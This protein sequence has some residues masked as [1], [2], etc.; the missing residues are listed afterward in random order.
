MVGN[1]REPETSLEDSVEVVDN[2]LTRGGDVGGDDVEVVNGVE[3]A[4]KILLMVNVLVVDNTGTDAVV[5][6]PPR[7]LQ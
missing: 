3:A 1:R 4:V 6:I 2:V 7:I 5:G